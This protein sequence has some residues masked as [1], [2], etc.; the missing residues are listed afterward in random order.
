MLETKIMN[1]TIIHKRMTNLN[2]VSV[3]IFWVVTLLGLTGRYQSVEEHTASIFRAEVC[4]SECLYLPT[5][6]QCY[7]PEDQH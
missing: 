2:F 1:G 4:S 5:S 6:P 3:F 7:S